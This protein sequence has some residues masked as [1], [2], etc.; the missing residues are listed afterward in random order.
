MHVFQGYCTASCGPPGDDSAL[1]GPE[2]RGRASS[3]AESKSASAGDELNRTS[4]EAVMLLVTS[5]C[6]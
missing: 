4:V 3:C 5:S 1:W 6:Q 2:S